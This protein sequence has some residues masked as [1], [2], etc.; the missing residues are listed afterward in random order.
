MKCGFLHVFYSSVPQIRRAMNAADI[1][2]I[3]RKKWRRDGKV[4]TLLKPAFN[5]VSIDVE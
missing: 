1:I 2:I 3:I 4:L 5:N